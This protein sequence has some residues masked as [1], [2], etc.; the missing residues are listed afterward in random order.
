MHLYT[1]AKHDGVTRSGLD[2]YEERIAIYNRDQG[3]CKTCGQPVPFDAFQLA[4][5]IAASKA[6]YHKYGAAIIDHPLNRVVSCPRPRCNDGA[7]ITGNPAACAELVAQIEAQ[8]PTS[9]TRS[10]ER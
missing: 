4:H 10:T 2:A 3:R 7:L 1:S 9:S 6:N 5:Q 8:S